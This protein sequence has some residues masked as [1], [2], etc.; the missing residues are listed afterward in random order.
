MPQDPFL[1]DQIDIEPGSVGT[2]RINRDPGTGGL[3]FTD[4]VVA[5]SLL[6][7][8]LAGLRNIA[9]VLIVGKSGAGAQYTTIQSALNVVPVGASATNPY[10]VLVL[11]GRYDETVNIVRDG[12]RLIGIGQPEIR[13]A[14][15]TTPDAV[16]ADHTLIVSAQLGTIPLTTLIEGF[17]ISN[18][19]STKAAVRLVGAAASTV[20]N[21]GI[22]IRNC[23]LRANSAV[24][25]YTLSAT[26][27]NNVFVEGGV[28]QE[29]SNLGLLLIQEVSV[30]RA[31]G[32]EGL[33][34]LSLR[35]DTAEDEP[36]NGGGSYIFNQCP[37]IALSTAMPTPIACDCD[38]GGRMEFNGCSL[39]TA[40]FSGDRTL[41]A[42]S[43]VFGALTLSETVEGTLSNCAHGTTNVNALAVLDEPMKGGSEA[44]GAALTAAVVFDLPF[45]DAAYQVGVEVDSQP[46]NDETAWITGKAATGFTINFASAQ[47]LTAT[48]RATR[49]D[50]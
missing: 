40:T 34:A 1:I 11:P 14:L 50:V 46:A 5:G 18:V 28:W 47:T 7:S 15:E 44:F 41:T 20:G 31:S 38:G 29:A 42:R 26:A 2:R 43:T 16:G 39:A 36:L 22:V 3:K 30:F 25:N 32:V 8:Q 24:G 13:S 12:V 49:T 33:G 6:L 19:H 21:V 9:N 4:P 10:I 17:I 35:Y 23:S 45:S 37:N 48:W 27:V